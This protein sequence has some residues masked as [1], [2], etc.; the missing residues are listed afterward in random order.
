MAGS[1][2]AR[3]VSLERLIADSAI[4]VAVFD[5]DMNYLHA[6]RGWMKEFGRG[7]ANLVGLNHYD[8]NPDIPE[9]WKKVHRDAMSGLSTEDEVDP[10]PLADGTTRLIKWA[11]QPWTDEAGEIGGIVIWAQDVTS[12]ALADAELRRNERLFREFFDRNS[13]I[14]LLINP[15]TMNIVAAN[16][17]AAAFYGYAGQSWRGMAATT[18]SATSPAAIAKAMRQALTTERMHFEARHRDHAGDWR[19]VEVYLTPV[20]AGGQ[21]LLLAIVHD[22]SERKHAEE[23]LRR[24]ATAIAATHD[25]VIVTNLEG[26]ILTINPA[27]TAIT[28][29]DEPELVG[30]NMRV[31]SSGRHDQTFYSKLW[32]GIVAEGYWQGEIWDR[33]KS[34]ELFPAWFTISRLTDELGRPDAYVAVFSDISRI[35]QA[36]SELEYLAHHDPL[37]GLPNRLLLLSRLK[38]A[39]ARSQ[40]TGTKLAVLFIDLDRFKNVNDALGHPA[41]DEL[42]K[43]VAGRLRRKLREVDT[44]ARLGGD[45]F[46]I[47]VENLTGPEGAATVANAAIAQLRKS[48]AL[49]AAPE[50]HIGCSIGISL[51]PDDALDADDLL[52]HADAALYRAKNAGRNTFRFY[53]AALTETASLHLSL[54]AR[55]HRAIDENQFV[56]HY[57]PLID[58][59]SQRIRGAEALLRWMPPGEAIILPSEFIPLAEETGLI[60]PLGEWVL[61]EACRQMRAWLSDGI[62][63][64]N[65]AVNISP[66]Q[67]QHPG[68]VDRLKADLRANQLAP[69][70]VALEIIESTL[71]TEGAANDA[72]LEALRQ[73]GVYLAIDDFGTGYSSLSNLRRFPIHQ[74]KIAQAFVQD[75]PDDAASREIAA[76]I[77]AM[78]KNLGLEVVAEGVENERQM[79]FLTSCGCNTFQG[80]LFSQPL[81]PD[82]FAALVRLPGKRWQCPASRGS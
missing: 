25:G 27:V 46:V 32:G 14:M 29:Y 67:F 3:T 41:G 31:F 47:L 49:A 59:S 54:E 44:L 65:L 57:Q 51:F 68:L 45:E 6:S 13:S 8:V 22:I 42:L 60:V 4:S 26:T 50:V 18:V 43:I 58:V 36:E 19:D 21:E 24:A 33:R 35:K 80:Y 10:W 15:R 48:I 79:Q 17:A 64:E 30:T 75:I 77:I 12:K 74:L 52:Q 40:R 56:L 82:Q 81:P 34:G 2:S 55:L 16:P 70:R 66:R 53:T 28:G 37:T 38:H 9:K 78:G 69:Q 62:A 72:K 61:A 39:I 11:V 23:A 63:L 1:K 5:R 7:H 73:L 71:M 76:T 20:R